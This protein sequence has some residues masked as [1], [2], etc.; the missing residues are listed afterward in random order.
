MSNISVSTDF[1]VFC[2]ELKIRDSVIDAIQ[3]RY[4]AI[5]K[6]VNIDYWNNES[7]VLH[8]RYVGSY[9]RGTCIYTSDIDIIVELPWS[10]YSKYEN[11]SGNGQSALL[12]SLRNCLQKTY[13]TS[14]ISADGQVVVISFSDGVIFEIVPAFKYS[15]SSGYCYP[16]TN[17]GG[18]WKSMDPKSEIDCFNGRNKICNGNLKRLCQMLRAWKTKHTVLMSG[19]LLDTTAYRFMQDY[20]YADKSYSYYDWMSRDYYKYLLNNAEKVYWEKPGNTGTVKRENFIKREAEYAYNKACEA[21]DDFSKGYSY[22]W[23]KNWRN[24]YGA[25]FPES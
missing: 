14:Q 13:S 15:D 23:H 7:E 19:I 22:S 16:D 25:R 2:K 5:T 8:S 10:E 3:S 4:H 21:I 17:N 20:K 12:S 6:R 11:Y 9:G 18:K 1:Q 24:L